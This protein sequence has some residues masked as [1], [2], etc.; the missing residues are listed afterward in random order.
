M[1]AAEDGTGT[2]HRQRTNGEAAGT[3]HGAIQVYPQTILGLPR[4]PGHTGRHYP[5]RGS[6]PRHPGPDAYG[7]RQEHH[8]PSAGH[9]DGGAVHRGHTPDCLDEGPGAA[10]T[11]EGHPGGSRLL[12]T[13]TR[14]DFAPLGQCHI[15]CLQVSLPV[16]RTVGHTAVPEQGEPH[17]GVSDHGGRGALH[18]AVGLRLPSALPAHRGYAPIAAGGARIGTDRHCHRGGGEG[19][20]PATE[21]H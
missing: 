1:K 14:G 12:G 21:F 10:P 8:L 3:F 17:E 2:A 6:R 9:G 20:L 11:A 13:N 18:L 4:L 19:Y 5:Q 7:G 15:R 16:A